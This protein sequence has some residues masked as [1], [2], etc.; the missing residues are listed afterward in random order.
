MED[1]GA[2]SKKVSNTQRDVG[3]DLSF[4][5]QERWPSRGQSP[6]GAAS[7]TRSSSTESHLNVNGSTDRWSRHG[8]GGARGH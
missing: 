2:A 7:S 3:H 5:A 8:R 4:C 1:C 6:G